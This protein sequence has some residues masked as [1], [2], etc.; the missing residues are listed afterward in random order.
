V[1]PQGRRRRRKLIFEE[2]F[3]GQGRVRGWVW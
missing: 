3:D 2:I 1:H